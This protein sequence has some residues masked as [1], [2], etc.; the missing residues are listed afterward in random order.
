[1]RIRIADENNHKYDSNSGH[2]ALYV[3]TYGKYADGSI[4]GMWVD[5]TTFDNKEDFL[6]WCSEELHADE[7]DPELM[8]QDSENIPDKYYSESSVSDELWEYIN[9]VKN[10]DKDMVDAVLDAGY[11]LSDLDDAMW[12]RGCSSMKD[13]AYEMCSE[14]G[15]EAFT[16]ETWE[17]VFDYDHFGREIQWDMDDE[18]RESYEGMSDKEI[19]EQYVDDI[20]GLETL[21]DETIENYADM[22]ELGRLIEQ[23]GGWVKYDGGYVKI[24]K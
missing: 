23:D 24:V 2:P 9:V 4:D 10:Y 7:S 11:E 16:R 17:S 3:G 8:F 13:V 18:E 21:G 19:G 5:L 1:M 12:Y 14:M 6:E 20:G 22:D 15:F